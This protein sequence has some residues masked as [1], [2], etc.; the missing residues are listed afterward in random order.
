L[1]LNV[2]GD[3]GIT[4]LIWLVGIKRNNDAAK[5]AIKLGADPNFKDG[6]GD[7]ALIFVAGSDDPERL[8]LLL[9][10]GGDPNSIDHVGMPVLFSAIGQDRMAD[11]ELLIDYGAG[12]NLRDKSGRNAAFYSIFIMRYK[13][14]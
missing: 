9:E 2:I 10:G 4:P 14:S 1:D 7:S 12:L 11:I 8:K 6:D 13:L 5:L 3:E